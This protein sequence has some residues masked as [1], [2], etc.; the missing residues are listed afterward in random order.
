METVYNCVVIFFTSF[1]IIDTEREGSK[2]S[3]HLMALGWS[4]PRLAQGL[5]KSQRVS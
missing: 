1:Y 5:L 2:R 3:R 4:I